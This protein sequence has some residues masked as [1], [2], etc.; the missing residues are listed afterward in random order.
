MGDPIGRAV[1]SPGDPDGTRRYGD[2]A[3]WPDSLLVERVVLGT[4]GAGVA[5]A[6]LEAELARRLT[7]PVQQGAVLRLLAAYAYGAGEY[8][9]E[10]AQAAARFYLAAH[11]A[12]RAPEP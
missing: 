5:R 10:D 2:P 8:A 6:T 4:P 11:V 9:G 1:A 7:D 3:S 12:S